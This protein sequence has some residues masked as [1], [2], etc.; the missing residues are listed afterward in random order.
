MESQIIFYQQ[1]KFS[2][3]TFEKLK[4]KLDN[5]GKEIKEAKGLPIEE[6]RK[7]ITPEKPLIK[8]GD[9][10]IGI[11]TGAKSNIIV[12]DCDDDDS[13]KKLLIDYPEFKN[14]YTVK[15]YKGH[16][17][18]CSYCEGI[19]TSIKK[20]LSGIDILSDNS[21]VYAPPT[22][23]NFLNGFKTE[24]KYLG[25]EI[26][27]IPNN[28][29]PILKEKRTIDKPSKSTTKNLKPVILEESEINSNYEALKEFYDLLSPKRF[30][31]RD[32]WIKSGALIYSLNH[33]LSLFIELSK[34]CPDKFQDG[35][36]ETVWKSYKYKSYGI[37]TLMYWCKQDNPKKFTELKLKYNFSLVQDKC[38]VDRTEI[39]QR[40]LL[41]KIDDEHYEICST[42]RTHLDSLFTTDLKILNIKS[43]YKTSKT[44]MMIKVI[45]EYKPKRILMLSYR[46][47]LTYDFDYN[48][49]NHGFQNYLEGDIAADRLIIQLESLL[50]LDFIDPF[51][52][53]LPVYDLI[54]MDESESILKQFSS[55]KTFKGTERDVLVGRAQAPLHKEN[56]FKES[57]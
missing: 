40:Y 29:I 45:E 26:L 44:Q 49:K 2:F 16:H 48:F 56:Y 50:R 33:P 43:P 53:K 47:T 34:K 30:H 6:K 14:Y 32:S 10:C 11:L 41:D 52:T 8:N 7:Q 25:G 54:I 21:I 19:P 46:K 5:K 12:I 38:L 27:A 35:A 20:K 55:H 37:G 23:Y 24:Y 42:M 28:L 4:T 31:D 18:Y 9:K 51:T 3:F 39:N 13:Y 1:K 36:C 57:R 17:I 15:T 22:S